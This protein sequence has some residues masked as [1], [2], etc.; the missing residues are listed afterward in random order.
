MGEWYR[1]KKRSRSNKSRKNR[2]GGCIGSDTVANSARNTYN[3][4]A[5]REQWKTDQE[6]ASRDRYTAENLADAEKRRQNDEYM[7]QMNE[8]RQ[9]QQQQQQQQSV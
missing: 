7:K 3:S 1:K 9:Q 6:Q 4:V 8:N 5:N 2:K